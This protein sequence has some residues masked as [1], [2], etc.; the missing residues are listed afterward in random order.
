MNSIRQQRLLKMM[1]IAENR[2]FSYDNEDIVGGYAENI[3]LKIDL[4]IFRS[5][6]LCGL[7]PV[8]PEAGPIRPSWY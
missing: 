3:D 2:H 7:P 6:R 1:A 4:R 8:S 5:K